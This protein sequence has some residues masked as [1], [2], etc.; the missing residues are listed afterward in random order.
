MSTVA[1]ARRNGVV[2]IGADTLTT[3]GSIKIQSK[4]K[5]DHSKLLPVGDGYLAPVGNGL[6]RQVLTEYV[7]GLKTAVAFDSVETIYRALCAMHAGLKE[8]QFLKPDSDEFEET[9]LVA[10]L[11]NP[12]GIFAVFHDRSVLEFKRFYALGSG[13]EFALGA[14][15]HA[16]ASGKTAGDIVRAGIEAGAEFDEN[17]GLP[18]EVHDVRLSGRRQVAST[19][20][21]R[22]TS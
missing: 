15:H 8:S 7:G 1:V 6:W 19:L 5:R 22:G 11:A 9:G 4:Y 2:A 20:D 3:H 14:M 12:H 18:L 17:S 13:A 10:V 21:G 16:Y